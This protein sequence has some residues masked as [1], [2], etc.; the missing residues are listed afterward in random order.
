[1]NADVQTLLR[2]QAYIG[3]EWVDAGSGKTFAVIN[4]AT[5]D[6]VAQVADC[7]VADAQ[8]AI[9]AAAKAQPDWAAKTAKER[10]V[11]LKRWFDLMMA[12]QEEL[13][14]LL[15]TE[16]GKALAEAKGEIAY[17]A[18][19]VE[20]FAEEGKRLYG[21]A[22]PTYAKD[23]RILVFKQPVGVCAS[24]TPWNFPTAMI[25]RKAG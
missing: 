12:N 24:I 9:D 8:R 17:G 25:A 1:M 20:W 6:V 7:G 10:A 22:I 4:P 14:A 18:S 19:F 11:I 21:D 5:G 13:G 23:R 16:Q 15:T 2:R 3:G